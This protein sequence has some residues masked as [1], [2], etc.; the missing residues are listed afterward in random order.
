MA[1]REQIDDP[2]SNRV[3]PDLTNRVRA[4]EAHLFEPLAEFGEGVRRAAPDCERKRRARSDRDRRRFGERPG[5]RREDPAPSAE[6]GPDRVH[7]LGLDLDVRVRV[8]VRERLA[9]RIAAHAPGTERAEVL[10]ERLGLVGHVGHED[11]GRTCGEVVECEREGGGSRPRER[12]DGRTGTTPRERLR[13]SGVAHDLE[14]R[15]SNQFDAPD[16]PSLPSPSAPGRRDRPGVAR[17]SSNP[18]NASASAINHGAK[19]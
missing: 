19:S 18:I 6:E 5:R 16:V 2:A 9:L 8:L 13:K 10:V 3:V 17:Y 4:P 1:E 12:V 7:A 15:R 11:D 14:E